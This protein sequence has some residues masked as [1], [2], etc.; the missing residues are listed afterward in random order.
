M[1]YVVDAKPR[2]AYLGFVHCIGE[3]N[4][5]KEKTMINGNK[6]TK[7]EAAKATDLLNLSIAA[8][9]A[10]NDKRVAGLTWGDVEAQTK[11]RRETFSDAVTK[12][13]PADAGKYD[14]AE[15]TCPEC[16]NHIVINKSFD[17]DCA[18]CPFCDEEIDLIEAQET[19]SRYVGRSALDT[20]TLDKQTSCHA[21]RQA[22]IDAYSSY[23]VVVDHFG[24]NTVLVYG[25]SWETGEAGFFENTPKGYSPAEFDRDEILD[26]LEDVKEMHLTA[27]TPRVEKI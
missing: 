9:E 11:S 18:D 8:E 26:A 1:Q 17:V 2:A 22:K 21:A 19:K 7:N 23:I 14:F 10:A 6:V 15:G 16:N 24:T 13:K 4:E 20:A 12:N 3:R 5:N 25:H 27:G